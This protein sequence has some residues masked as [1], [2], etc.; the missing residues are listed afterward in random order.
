MD[1]EKSKDTNETQY[2]PLRYHETLDAFSD[3]IEEHYFECEIDVYRTAVS[4]PPSEFDITPRRRRN[5]GEQGLELPFSYTQEEIDMMDDD[6]KKIEIG[7]DAISVHKTELKEIKEAKRA[8]V[9]FGK[10][11]S[12]EEF[13]DYKYNQRGTYVMKLHITPDK[14]LVSKKFHSST[15]HGNILLR[16]GV[17]I[18]DILDKEYEIKPFKYEDDDKQ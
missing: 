5:A 12:K 4:N 3:V 11:H 17:T 18:D 1:I 9:D 15:G 6:T 13:E 10:K 7:R 14:A 16:E 8:A 2:A